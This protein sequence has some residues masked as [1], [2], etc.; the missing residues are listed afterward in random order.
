[1]ASDA[2][3]TES[4]EQI[5]INRANVRPELPAKAA[6]RQSWW[7]WRRQVI[8]ITLAVCTLAGVAVV[9]FKIRSAAGGPRA[10]RAAVLDA[11]KPPAPPASLPE[12][13]PNAVPVP[14]AP[15]HKSRKSIEPTSSPPKK[16]APNTRE[17][18]AKRAPTPSQTR[19]NPKDELT[20]MWIPVGKFTMGCSPGDSECYVDEKPPHEVTI[21]RGFWIG[22][23][24]VTVAAYSQ[25]RTAREGKNP[26]NPDVPVGNVNWEQANA[27]CERAGL[28]LPSEAEW[29]YAAR[30]NTTGSRYGTLD[31]VAWFSGKEWRETAFCRWK[32]TERLGAL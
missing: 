11:A 14:H 19:Q 24:E 29:E 31:A 1:V 27:Y 6:E 28:R 12:I 25:F 30:A 15:S 9:T 17:S 4:L 32:A 13:S 20:Y 7:N 18:A 26:E 22:K 5:G 2:P 23:T 21:T 16:E 8:A 10:Q 3:R